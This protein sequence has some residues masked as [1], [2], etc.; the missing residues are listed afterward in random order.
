M[1][2]HGLVQVVY[3]FSLFMHVSVRRRRTFCWTLCT[4]MI[5]MPVMLMMAM[6]IA[7]I[8]TPMWIMLDDDDDDDADDCL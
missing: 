8:M 7:T 1:H 6:P 5:S 4:W 3:E 2:I